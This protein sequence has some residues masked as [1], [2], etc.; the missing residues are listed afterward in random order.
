VSVPVRNIYYLLCY[1]WD[2][3][4][5]S[6]P[7]EAGKLPF[8][9]LPDL[10]AAVLAAGTERLLKR[11]LD[12]GYVAIE[13]DARTPRGKLNLSETLKRNLLNL[14]AVHCSVDNL[15]VDIP[16]NRVLRATLGR[17]ARCD[18][19]DPVLRSRCLGL[20]RRFPGVADVPVTAGLLS[21]VQLH[22]NIRHYR[23]VIEVCRLLHH[24]LL[25]E[26]G[27]GRVA[28]RDFLRDDGLMAGLFERFVQNFYRREQTD[29][30]RVGPER[31]EWQDVAA[32]DNARRYLPEM[33][34][35]VCLES[36]RRKL[37]VDCK[38]SSQTLSAYYGA[39][40]LHAP[41]L[42]QLF[43]YLRNL[44]LQIVPGQTLEGMLLYPTVDR[45]LD[46][47]YMVHGHSVRVATID[48]TREWPEIHSRLLALIKS[49]GLI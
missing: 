27:T 3:L 31:V 43:A 14:P 12:R 48:L 6:G 13:E 35:D 9:R 25:S 42:Y 10:P 2:A 26:P 34:T 32:A 15:A 5:E 1:A 36:P 16:H 7:V 20:Y 45:E 29:F 39:Q 40:K 18:A 38:Y 24:A 33:R 41:H 30:P 22:R 46:L 11:G 21:R 49:P 8:K 47:R 4:E 37:V 17:V 28:F 19:I 23:L 44:A